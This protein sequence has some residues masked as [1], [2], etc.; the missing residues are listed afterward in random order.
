MLEEIINQIYEINKDNE[1]TY[2]FIETKLIEEMG[3]LTQAMLKYDKDSDKVLE[4]IADV[5]ILLRQ[6]IKGIDTNRLNKML[7]FKLLRTQQRLNIK[8]N[9]ITTFED[10]ISRKEL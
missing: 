1:I 5:I 6:Y 2:G 7:E 3:E 8:D 9:D 10:Y 4:E